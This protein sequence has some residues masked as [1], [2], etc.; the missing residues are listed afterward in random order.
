MINKFP[1][2]IL[3]KPRTQAQI[4]K[5]KYT[6]KPY[7]EIEVIQ[8]QIAK[9]LLIFIY[10]FHIDSFLAVPLIQPIPFYSVLY[11]FKSTI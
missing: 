9:L 10:L 2:V 8:D 3:I 6:L 5:Y 1:I 11:T 4:H 7:I